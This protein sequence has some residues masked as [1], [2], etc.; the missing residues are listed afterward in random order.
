MNQPR[1][2]FER[3]G[4]R[5]AAVTLAV[6]ATLATGCDTFTD[7]GA[8]LTEPPPARNAVGLPA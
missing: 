1:N 6:A 2:T 3:L 5:I 4:R 8:F 7:Y